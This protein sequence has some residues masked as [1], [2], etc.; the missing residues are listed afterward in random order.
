MRPRAL[1]L[2]GAAAVVSTVAAVYVSVDAQRDVAEAARLDEPVFAA[3]RDAPEIAAAITVVHGDREIVVERA[4]E[5][6]IVPARHGY[7][8][9]ESAVRALLTGLADLRWAGPRTAMPERYARLEVDD[10]GEGSA[11]TRVSVEADD[12]TVLVDAIIGKRSQAITGDERGT[13]LRLVDGERAWLAFGTVD[14][15]TAAV[16]WLDTE[17]PSLAR[18]EVEM[19][20]VDPAK[21]EGF[22][23]GRTTTQ[24]DM[25]LVDQLPAGEAADANQIRRLAGVFAGLRFEDVRPADA[26]DWPE[27][28]TTVTGTSFDDG[29]LTVELADLGGGE[30]DRWVRFEDIGDWVYQLPSFQADRLDKRLDDLLATPE[31][32]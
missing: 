16:D 18:E 3:L 1:I 20:V 12:G 6:W 29:T 4:G 8:A 7:E 25:T 23:A 28:V 19:V 13:Y 32:S 30:D 24:D 10:A 17:L 9:D 11:A 21:G 26:V 5:R 2:W 14:V 31:A 27:A 22:T 15:A